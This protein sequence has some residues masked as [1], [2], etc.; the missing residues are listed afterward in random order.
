M[1]HAIARDSRLTDRQRTA[2]IDIYRSFISD[3][4]RHDEL[5]NAVTAADQEEIA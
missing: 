4:G 3:T 2:L 1:E 5:E